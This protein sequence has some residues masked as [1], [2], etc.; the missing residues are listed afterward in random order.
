LLTRAVLDGSQGFFSKR[1]TIPRRLYVPIT[2]FP[3]WPW[4]GILPLCKMIMPIDLGCTLH[5]ISRQVWSSSSIFVSI[6]CSSAVP[7]KSSSLTEHLFSLPHQYESLLCGL[8]P[9][10]IPYVG[11]FIFFRTSSSLQVGTPWS[12]QSPTPFLVFRML[13]SYNG[14]ERALVWI[15]CRSSPPAIISNQHDF[16]LST[17]FCRS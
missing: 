13:E 16:V 7:Y 12:P 6:R 15:G 10:L 5:G 11:P 17:I 4:F 1:L 14:V 3:P 9:P 8:K 2:A